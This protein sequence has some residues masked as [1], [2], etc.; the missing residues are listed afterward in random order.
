MAISDKIEYLRLD[1]LK[2]DGKNPRLGREVTRTSPDQD[3]ILDHM[4]DWS[5]DELAVSFIDSGY[6]PQE[7]MIVVRKEKITS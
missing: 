3:A 5:L 2:L 6:W 7:A 4:I 1:Q